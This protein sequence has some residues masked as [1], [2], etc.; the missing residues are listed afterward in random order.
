MIA[1]TWLNEQRCTVYFCQFL[2]DQKLFI[3]WSLSSKTNLKM[4]ASSIRTVWCTI[5]HFQES[6]SQNKPAESFW[7]GFFYSDSVPDRHG[8]KQLCLFPGSFLVPKFFC[9]DAILRQV[10]PA[11]TNRT[12]GLPDYGLTPVAYPEFRDRRGWR[13]GNRRSAS[14]SRFRRP[15]ICC[16]FLPAASILSRSAQTI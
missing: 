16:P 15:S 4:F 14:W 3:G 10:G 5:F 1:E 2:G 13:S 8:W 7:E 6:I 12:Q 9:C 11:L